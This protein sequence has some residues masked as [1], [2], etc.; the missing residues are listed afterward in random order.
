MNA[1]LERFFSSLFSFFLVKLCWASDRTPSSSYWRF[2]DRLENFLICAEI[3]E[4]LA[5]STETFEYLLKIGKEFV[6]FGART[7]LPMNLTREKYKRKRV[8]NISKKKN[9][10]MCIYNTV[11]ELLKRNWIK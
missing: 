7:S 5:H 3:L 11:S 4:T 8:V 9:I 10:Y 2:D 6:A 1:R